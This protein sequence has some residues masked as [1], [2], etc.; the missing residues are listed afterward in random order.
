MN[1]VDKHV[2][3]WVTLAVVLSGIVYLI[4]KGFYDGAAVW[5]LGTGL[6]WCIGLFF[7]WADL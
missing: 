1:R 5:T 3:T 6:S 7:L 2:L 4:E